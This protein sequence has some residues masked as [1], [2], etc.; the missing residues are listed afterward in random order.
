MN[1]FRIRPFALPLLTS[2]LAFTRP[3]PSIYGR[4]AIGFYDASTR[5]GC[6]AQCRPPA[7]NAFSTTD[8]AGLTV[9]RMPDHAVIVSWTTEKEGKGDYYE[10]ERSPDGKDWTIVAVAL[11]GTGIEN[12]SYEYIDKGAVAV[13]LYYRIR[14]RDGDGK[15]SVSAVA[16]VE[17]EARA[18]ASIFFADK[19][20]S[21]RLYGNVKDALE[22]SILDQTGHL[23]GQKK[24]V[25]TGAIIRFSLSELT[26][27]RYTLNI[28]D[29]IGLIGTKKLVI[30]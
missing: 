16:T 11:A 17:G 8:I 27:G 6:A 20:I 13:A 26:P 18:A 22:I 19:N 25:D 7:Q 21:I 4:P 23:L 9:T 14:Q 3:V 15:Y 1:P 5:Y 30:R 24:I 29:G 2:L 28:A 10:I 12:N